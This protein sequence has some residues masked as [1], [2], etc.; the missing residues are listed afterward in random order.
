MVVMTIGLFA[1]DSETGQKNMH[2]LLRD[3]RAVL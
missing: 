3:G 1:N 2:L